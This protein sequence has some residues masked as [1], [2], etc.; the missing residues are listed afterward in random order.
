MAQAVA[1]SAQLQSSAQPLIINGNDVSK[2]VR[3]QL[4]K[5]VSCVPS[6]S[7]PPCLAVVLVGARKDSQ[8]YVN[9]KTKAC[10]EV[11]I[12]A[13]QI[14]LAEN[15]TQEEI[16][17]VVRELN[18]DAAVHGILVQLPLPAH[19]S[20]DQVI[21]EIRSEKDVDGLTEFNQGCVMRWGTKANLPSCTPAGCIE[22][23]DHYGIPIAGKS[24]IVLGR[25]ILVGKPVAQ[26]LLSRDATVTIAHS[27]TANLPELVKQ[28]DIIVAAIGRAE[29]VRG[30]WI[31]PGAVVIDVGMNAVPDSTKKAG[32]RLVGDVN[33]NEAVKVASAITPVPGGVGPMTVAMLLRNTLRAYKHLQSLDNNNSDN[34]SNSTK[35]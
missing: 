30:E 8:T 17:R 5:E 31:K 24:A 7:C 12:L 25:S 11:G 9:M 23:L 3:A 33:Y 29:F 15:T 21:A 27:K 35:Q 16:V 22:L 32:H 6:S 14:D 10:K 34:N 20:Q 1:E 2:S 18:A 26:L 4:T 13:K 28:A 19:C